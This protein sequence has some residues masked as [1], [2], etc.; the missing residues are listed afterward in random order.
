[1]KRTAMPVTFNSYVTERDPGV[2]VLDFQIKVEPG[3]ARE[4]EKLV[5]E[6]ERMVIDLKEQAAEFEKVEK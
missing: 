5:P 3:S 6:L 1:M 4:I 2:K